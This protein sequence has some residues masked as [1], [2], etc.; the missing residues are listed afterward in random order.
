M[1]D[2]G[3]KYI[4]CSLEN[5][6]HSNCISIRCFWDYNH[7]QTFIKRARVCV[8]VRAHLLWFGTVA[9]MN[10]ICWWLIVNVVLLLC[11]VSCF[12]FLSTLFW[13]ES[14]LNWSGAP[15]QQQWN[16]NNKDIKSVHKT[17]NNF[18]RFWRHLRGSIHPI[19]HQEFNLNLFIACNFL[20]W[21]HAS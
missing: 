20:L 9:D 15:K 1:S 8:C 3:K 16:R 10:G 18:H 5:I 21:L 13:E 17:W 14:R 7:I 11:F 6:S 4:F 2:D 12:F 19:L